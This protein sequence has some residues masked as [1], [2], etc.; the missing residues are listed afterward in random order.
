MRSSGFHPL[1]VSEVSIQILTSDTSSRQNVNHAVESV[2]GVQRHLHGNRCHME[3]LR[4]LT[5]NTFIAGS[6]SVQLIHEGQHRNPMPVRLPPDSL[7]LGLY[8]ADTA[9]HGHR[10][11]QNPKHSL[12]FRREIHMAGSIDHVDSYITPL[13]NHRSA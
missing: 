10:A 2:F 3:A 1:I 7:G 9:E 8:T 12:H 4:Y 11:I 5:N 6:L 13:A